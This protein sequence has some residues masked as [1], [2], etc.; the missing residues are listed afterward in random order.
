VVKPL[1]KRVFDH[2]RGDAPL[3]QTDGRSEI[4]RQS[5]VH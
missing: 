5:A 1:V 4:M 2:G 3:T